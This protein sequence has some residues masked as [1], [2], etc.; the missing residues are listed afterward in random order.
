MQIKYFLCL[1]LLFLV[2]CTIY[3]TKQDFP[4]KPE[5]RWV[6][7][8]WN[9]QG[10]LLTETDA[11]LWCFVINQNLEDNLT[12][13]AIYSNSS[14]LFLEIQT[15]IGNETKLERKRNVYSDCVEQ[16]LVKKF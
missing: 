7:H 4:I 3:K 10:A 5:A 6:C 15:T 16:I 12:C 9:I 1:A 13:I 8:K 2:G 11:K 14:S